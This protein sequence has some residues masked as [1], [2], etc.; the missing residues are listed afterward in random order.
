[1]KISTIL[2]IIVAAA[3]VILCVQLVMSKRTPSAPAD[4]AVMNA[5]LSRT[6]VRSYTDQAVEPEKIE[7]LLRAGMAAPSAVNKQPWHFVVVTERQ[8]LDALGDANPH[9]GFIKQAPLA[10]VVCGDM[11]KAL[12]GG[13]REFWIQDCSAAT[14]NILVAATGLGL[15]A[16]WTGTYPAQERCQAVA[17]VL[18]LPETLIPLNTIVI[19]YPDADVQPKDKWKP[20]NI[21]YNF[22]GGASDD[23]V[24]AVAAVPAKEKTFREFDVQTDFRCDPFTWFKGDGLL[25]CAGNKSSYN[26]M[27]IG[28]GALGN[29]W[30]RGTST[31]TVYVAPG[32]YTHQFMEKTKF[33]TVMVFD[34]EHRNVL[35]YMG[36]NS[37]RDGDKVK[38]LGL[39][40]LY[41]DNGTPY[42]EEA[43]EVYECEMI[44]HA[45]FDPQGFGD[46]PER[47]YADFKPGI[48]S[49]YMGKIVRAMRKQ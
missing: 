37:G 30:E 18:Q 12:E 29:I 36:H 24:T 40:T 38:A 13:G 28:W 49:L 20:E 23:P 9:A 4:E 21:S 34:G 11:T 10:I 31:I 6:S 33:F 16:T 42:F 27:T 32:R 41:T 45:P 17:Q 47:F 15:G 48:H 19:G 14:E 44:Y 39:H 25:L 43:S 7:Q 46:M 2:N 8:T 35:D 3:L 26:A 1:M 22:F 5:I